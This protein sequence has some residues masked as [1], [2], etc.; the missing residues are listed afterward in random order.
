MDVGVDE[1]A[2]LLVFFGVLAEFGER[3]SLFFL[4]GLEFSDFVRY[5]FLVS[6]FGRG[7]F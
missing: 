2:G 3:F 7:F 5:Y 1:V 6:S 4:D